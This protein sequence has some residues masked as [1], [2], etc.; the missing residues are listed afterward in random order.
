MDVSMK[1]C[2]IVL[3]L[4]TVLC[5][6]AAISSGRDPRVS[7]RS[8]GIPGIDVRLVSSRFYKVDQNLSLYLKYLKFCLYHVHDAWRRDVEVPGLALNVTILNQCRCFKTQ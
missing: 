3:E 5:T 1:T 6:D 8:E 4:L 2:A 7:E